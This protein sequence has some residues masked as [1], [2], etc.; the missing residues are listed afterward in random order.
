MDLKTLKTFQLIVKYG[1]FIRAAQ[2]MN[3]VQST[4]TMQIKKLE[5]ELG[6][7]LIERGKEIGLT[8]AGR[9]FYEQSLQI[10]KSM[11]NLQ[12]SLSDLTSGETGH[13]R[14]GVTEPTASYRLP[15]ILEKFMSAYPNIRISI[16]ISNT[17]ALTERI[18]KG[19]IDF[20]ICT[21]P[22]ISSEFYFEPLFQEEFVVLMPEN[23]PL[24]QKDVLEPDDFRG[25]RLLITSSTCPYRRKL[26]LVMQ[27]KGNVTLDTMEIGS[28]TALKFYVEKG[29]GIALVP[30]ITVEPDKGTLVKM[31]SGSLV[32]MTFGI[33]CKESAYPFQLASQKLYQYI[34]RELV[35]HSEG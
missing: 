15:G 5:S 29:I 33:L 6:V 16:E 35:T 21:A 23:H 18:L 3:Y 31:I 27:E 7:L 10:V 12:S 9:L 25:H 32:H 17:P 2:E 34:K 24:S 22:S 19:E 8:E 20:S 11:E 26:E 1:S 14:I 30:K 28:M 13:I 4:V